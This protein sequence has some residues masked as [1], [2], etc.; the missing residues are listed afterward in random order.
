MASFPCKE[1]KGYDL[2]V[3]SRAEEPVMQHCVF[4]KVVLL[5]VSKILSPNSSHRYM[6]DHSVKG[7][8]Y[9]VHVTC[10]L[11]SSKR[12][13]RALIGVKKRLTNVFDATSQKVDDFHAY[14][15]ALP[16]G[17]NQREPCSELDTRF[18]SK[19]LVTSDCRRGHDAGTHE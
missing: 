2:P 12:E 1:V 6:H 5:H 15:F 17:G 4:C 9:F 11:P 18:R 7:K 16:D 10:F 14:T 3:L 19:A 8:R 13:K